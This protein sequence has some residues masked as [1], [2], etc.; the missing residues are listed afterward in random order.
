M[1]FKNILLFICCLIATQLLAQQT[2]VAELERYS[3]P[4]TTTNPH[5]VNFDELLPLKDVLKNVPLVGVGEATH[6]TADFFELRHT[7]FK[8]LVEQNNFT[9]LGIETGYG[10]TVPL[11]NYIQ[12]GEGDPYVL[13]NDLGLFPFKHWQ[14]YDLVVW[15]RNYNL[16]AK[17]KLSLFGFNT[18]FAKFSIDKTKEI[19]V[20]NNVS[21]DT[22]R[23][24]QLNT[25]RDKNTFY[26]PRTFTKEFQNK[27]HP[28]LAHFIL[29]C[30]NNKLTINPKDTTELNA[31]LF[32]LTQLNTVWFSEQ[33]MDKAREPAM[34]NLVDYNTQNKKTMLWAHN[35]H[36][37]N[38]TAYYPSMG[39]L[40]KQRHN[41]NYYTIGTNFG[42][43]K[44]MAKNGKM[45][46]T[47]FTIRHQYKC[48][49]AKLFAK[50]HPNY[51]CYFIDFNIA[52]QSPTI[53]KI[54]SR[55]P[56]IYADAFFRNTNKLFYR[57]NFLVPKD[58]YIQ[59]YDGYFYVKVTRAMQLLN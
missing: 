11:N 13:I 49:K 26:N 14:L 22:N 57:L 48:T 58:K 38:D 37:D 41:A 43:G 20:R 7:L 34:A 50:V 39:A 42:T 40:L 54:F 51:N 9:Q 59:M 36:I 3:I 17:N 32:N 27:I 19:M 16:T 23:F 8:F 53:T 46:L 10:E 55:L 15:M 28:V 35:A 24:V 4:I 56:Y 2:T 47:T 52:K 45:K 5:K 21:I 1:K 33:N 44:F 29:V 31:H 30:N 6:G 12:T 18:G 25:I